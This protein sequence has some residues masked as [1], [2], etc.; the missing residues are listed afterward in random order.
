MWTRFFPSALLPLAA[1]NDFSSTP[2]AAGIA[3][4]V[5]SLATLLL[6]RYLYPPRRDE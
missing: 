3:I 5:L 4:F 1:A 2:V 6:L